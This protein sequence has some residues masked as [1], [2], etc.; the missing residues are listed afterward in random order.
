MKHQMSATYET[1]SVDFIITAGGLR[2]A[3][4]SASAADAGTAKD[5][6]CSHVLSEGLPDDRGGRHVRAMRLR[7]MP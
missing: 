2:T 1:I 6:L 7:A 5:A 4:A 3:A